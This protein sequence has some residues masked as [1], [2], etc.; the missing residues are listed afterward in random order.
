[1]RTQ[2]RARARRCFMG[3]SKSALGRRAAAWLQ[4]QEMCYYIITRESYT[5]GVEIA[6]DFF[7]ARRTFSAFGVQ[8]HTT[9]TCCACSDLF[10]RVFHFGKKSG[11]EF[12][13]WNAFVWTYIKF[14]DGF[15]DSM[16]IRDWNWWANSDKS[17]GCSKQA[18]SL[19]SELP[20][21]QQCKLPLLLRGYSVE[22]KNAEMILLRFVEQQLV[23]TRNYI[24]K[25]AR[26]TCARL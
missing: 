10:L 3:R 2:K 15:F 5:G 6:L 9:R 7:S 19:R 4:R 11:T 1:M 13:L 18:A 20:L 21:I 26:G 12:H 25:L 22:S 16:R 8:T 14:C 17:K 23:T 24:K